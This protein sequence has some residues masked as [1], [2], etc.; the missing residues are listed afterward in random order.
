MKRSRIE[1]AD[2]AFDEDFGS[3][4]TYRMGEDSIF[5]QDCLKNNLRI[6]YIPRPIGSVDV[7]QSTWFRGYDQQHFL[8]LGAIYRR[9]FP[10]GF[11]VMLTQYIVRK[12]ADFKGAV[13]TSEAVR[14][15]ASGAFNY[16]RTLN[17]R[18]EQCTRGA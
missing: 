10:L 5:L 13:S 3:G 18:K 2:I 15:V 11:P 6:L 9:M 7:S 16:Q 12:R 14:A 4:S 8:A 17:R 1:R